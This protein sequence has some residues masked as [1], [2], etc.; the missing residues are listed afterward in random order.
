MRVYINLSGDC[1]PL[2]SSEEIEVVFDNQ[3]DGFMRFWKLPYDG[4]HEGGLWRLKH[5][6]FLSKNTHP[7]VKFYGISRLRKGIPGGLEPY[8]GYAWFCLPK[9]FV[10][11]SLDFIKRNSKFKSF[12]KSTFAPGEMFFQT[13][14]MNSGFKRRIQND[15]KRFMEF[16]GSHPKILTIH[17][18]NELRKS[19]KL[20]AR[21]FDP[22]VDKMIIDKL[23]QDI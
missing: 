17:D 15:D 6:I 21:K 11:Y 13:I 16:E 12:Y 7:Y 2:R 18:Y 4:W 3:T 22:A 23:D 9:E 5:F 20:F 14:L 19:G 8:G 10:S 1:Y